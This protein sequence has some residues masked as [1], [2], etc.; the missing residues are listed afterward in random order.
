MKSKVDTQLTKHADYKIVAIYSQKKLHQIWQSFY[1][2]FRT[3]GAV[4]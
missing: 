1:C 4:I 2:Y 3:S